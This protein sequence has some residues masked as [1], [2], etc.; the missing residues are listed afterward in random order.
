MS[1]PSLPRM[2]YSPLLAALIEYTPDAAPFLG[3]MVKR[4]QVDAVARVAASVSFPAWSAVTNCPVLVSWSVPALGTYELLNVA[5][6]LAAVAE[7][8]RFV[9]A[10]EAAT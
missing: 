1:D 10:L 5:A 7:A 6:P 4:S 8:M 9:F 3:R 2:T